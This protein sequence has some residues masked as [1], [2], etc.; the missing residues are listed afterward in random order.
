M[1]LARLA[2]GSH[3]VRSIEL[4]AQ[5]FLQNHVV[6]SFRGMRVTEIK[7]VVG[8]IQQFVDIVVCQ[9]EMM[10]RDELV[11]EGIESG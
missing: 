11:S 6:D 7:I 2:R 1:A 5:G 9:E 8:R 10:E 4:E 3:I